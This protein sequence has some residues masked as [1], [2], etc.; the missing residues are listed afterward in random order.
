VLPAYKN[1]RAKHA[2]LH[3]RRQQM[4]AFAR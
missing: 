3:T 1:L 2:Q 4:S